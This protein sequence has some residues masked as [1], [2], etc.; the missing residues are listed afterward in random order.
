MSSPKREAGSILVNGFGTGAEGDH[1]VMHRI[2]R[3]LRA[4]GIVYVGVKDGS[5]IRTDADG[6]LYND[7]N[8]GEM[9][10]LVRKGGLKG[11]ES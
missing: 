8:A 2:V 1:T 7:M 5:G 3:A 4:G 11:N 6:R 10:Q 9:S